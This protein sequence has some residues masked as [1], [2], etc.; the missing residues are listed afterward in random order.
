MPREYK[1]TFFFGIFENFNV[2]VILF[3]LR[4]RRRDEGIERIIARMELEELN[5]ASIF[6][7]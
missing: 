4:I 1:M 3:G 2:L 7:K 5:S 6:A